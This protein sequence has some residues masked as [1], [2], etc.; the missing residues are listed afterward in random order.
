M[1][2]NFKE[3]LIASSKSRSTSIVL[4]FYVISVFLL[5][6]FS[7]LDKTSAIFLYILALLFVGCLT[8]IKSSPSEDIVRNNMLI[9]ILLSYGSFV[10][11]VY[12]IFL[13]LIYLMLNIPM[14][15][16]NLIIL[17]ILMVIFTFKIE[18]C[19]HEYFRAKLFW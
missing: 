8:S 5:F 18:S 1:T 16:V 10:H 3:R 14:N 15:T 9:Y 12:L 13:V 7:V 2:N 19:I 17:I 11:D 4:L 6:H